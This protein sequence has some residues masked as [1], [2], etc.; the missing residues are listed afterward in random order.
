[1]CF[2]LR[3]ATKGAQQ[4]QDKRKCPCRA[5]AAESSKKKNKNKKYKKRL[6]ENDFL[7]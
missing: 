4:L 1:M 2:F 5:W 7:T 6:Q 3:C